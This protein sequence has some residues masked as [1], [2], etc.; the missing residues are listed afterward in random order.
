MKTFAN[1]LSETTLHVGV[2]LIESVLEEAAKKSAFD[3]AQIDALR[4]AYGGINKIDP[5]GDAYKKLKTIISSM[6]DEMLKSVVDA[7]INFVSA[8]ARNELFRREAKKSSVSESKNQDYTVM[9]KDFSSAVQH[10][11]EVAEKRGFEIDEED[12]ANK[13]SSGPRK[14]GTGK[15]NSYNIELMK[16]GKA[17]K[18]LLH[19]QVYNTGNRYEL[20]MYIS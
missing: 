13:V 18:K 17:S 10:A 15:T 1:L 3:K 16:D 12:W 9:H 20:N 6:K 4:M 5:S 11:I 8:L 14:P 19:M 7:K 2:D